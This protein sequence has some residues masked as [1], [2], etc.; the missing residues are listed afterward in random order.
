[1]S[2]YVL[3]VQSTS[4]ALKAEK[5]LRQ[6]LIIPKLIPVPRH[7]SSDC[8]VC[9]RISAA[10]KDPIIEI[11]K[12]AKMEIKSEHPFPATNRSNR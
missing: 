3:L 7:L 6:H 8:G 10:E 12:N 2:H 1:M 9:L 11:L 5:L 4:H